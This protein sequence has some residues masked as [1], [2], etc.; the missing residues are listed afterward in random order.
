RFGISF[1]NFLHMLHQ[2]LPNDLLNN[3]IAVLTNCDELS[4]NLEASVLERELNVDKSK[5]FYLQNS[6]FRWDRKMKSEKTIRRFRQNFEDNLATIESLVVKL[7][8]FRDVSTRSFSVSASKISS[9]EEYVKQ[10]I[11]KMVNLLRNYNE[12]QVAQAG[13]AGARDTMENNKQW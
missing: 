13:I 1:K 11:L 6:L 10:S 3:C 9:I 4:V 7:P 12:R 2:M 5:T 8:K